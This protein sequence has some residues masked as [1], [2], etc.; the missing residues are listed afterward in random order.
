NTR[1]QAF[2]SAGTPLSFIVRR[3][4]TFI[5]KELG[6]APRDF[7]P[8]RLAG[9]VAVAGLALAA[10]CASL[11]R[12][13]RQGAISSARTAVCG[14]RA[15]DSLCVVRSVERV[16]DGYRVV[17]DRRPPAGADRLA[18]LVRGGWIGGHIDVTPVDT[19][20]V[21]RRP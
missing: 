19:T 17:L 2:V 5:S 11:G 18:V 20:T 6:M 7:L 8:A 9:Q 21:P 15:A 4:R 14:S 12:P 1:A 3:R 10:G 16:E 13:S